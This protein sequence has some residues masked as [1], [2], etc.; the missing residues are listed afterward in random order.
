MFL[1]AVARS[2]LGRGSV[3]SEVHG[4]CCPPQWKKAC[5]EA[6]RRQEEAQQQEQEEEQQLEVQQQQQ[7]Q[8]RSKG[9]A[10]RCV[11]VCTQSRLPPGACLAATQL[12]I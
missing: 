10:G 4:R 3:Q 8:E 7:Q 2:R 1:S 9:A 11:G 5:L 6:R 12:K